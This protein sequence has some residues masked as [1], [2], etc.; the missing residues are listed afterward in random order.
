MLPSRHLT[1][2]CYLVQSPKVSNTMHLSLTLHN[3]LYTVTCG[4]W[5]P[6]LC[7]CTGATSF[8][9]GCCPIQSSPW[10]WKT[11]F[12][13]H[14]THRSNFNLRFLRDV[15]KQGVPDVSQDR[16]VFSFKVK[17]TLKM[18][19]LYNLSKRRGL[20][21]KDTASHPRRLESSAVPLG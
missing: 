13:T 14:T 20:C 21:V 7:S 16:N 3:C 10:V 15:T 17:D 5:G 11:K 1:S 4:V 19:T 18:R 6:G 9:L 12:L 2:Y 8:K